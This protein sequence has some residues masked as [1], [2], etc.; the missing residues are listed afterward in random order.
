MTVNSI[1]AGGGDRSAATIR[2]ESHLSGAT[3]KVRSAVINIFEKLASAASSGF[4]ETVA[5][6]CWVLYCAQTQS[7]F[8]AIAGGFLLGAGIAASSLAAKKLSQR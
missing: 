8:S 5:V 6:T 7:F 2:R 3:R 1:H 4:V